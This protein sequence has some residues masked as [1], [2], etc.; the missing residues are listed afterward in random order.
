[1]PLI[2]AS[3]KL[4]NAMEVEKL[5]SLSDVH[6]WSI[7]PM[8]GF[9]YVGIK[10][11]YEQREVNTIEVYN[12]DRKAHQ[13]DSKIAV[14]SETC[15]EVVDTRWAHLRKTS[16]GVKLY[17]FRLGELFNFDLN[18]QSLQCTL[19]E[20]FRYSKHPGSFKWLA[21]DLLSMGNLFEGCLTVFLPERRKFRQMRLPASKLK[22]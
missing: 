5:L 22:T 7:L 12:V 2:F 8:E 19:K 1:M 6:V 17:A 9:L 14:F 16:D 15:K 20:K 3:S 4:A 18:P 10:R 11:V 13:E 21:P